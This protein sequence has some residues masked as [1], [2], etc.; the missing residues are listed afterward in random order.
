MRLERIPVPVLRACRNLDMSDAE[1]ER[2]S[3][4][5]LFGHYLQWEGIIGYTETI[6]EIATK[7]KAAGGR[8]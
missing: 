5:E 6:W 3:P 8:R 7:L 1:I 4:K 2:S